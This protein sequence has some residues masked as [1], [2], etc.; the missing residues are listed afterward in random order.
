MGLAQPP[1]TERLGR[2]RQTERLP[3]DGAAD[4]VTVE[5]LHR[6]G[7]PDDWDRA[8]RAVRPVDRADDALEQVPRGKR[9][10]RVVAHDDPEIRGHDLQRQADRILATGAPSHDLGGRMQ[11]GRL[12]GAPDR[13]DVGRRSGDDDEVHCVA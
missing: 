11:G 1:G 9:T 3:G 8:I 6:I 10:R 4:G 7:R 5:L 13:R 12:D 2:L